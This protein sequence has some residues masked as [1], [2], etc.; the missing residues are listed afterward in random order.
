MGCGASTPKPPSG[1]Q[2]ASA[3]ETRYSPIVK[4]HEASISTL[5]KK[6]DADSDG[7]LVA[8][9]LKD[10]VSKYTGEA[11]DEKQ[12]F[13]WFDVHG[14]GG[15]PDSQLDLKEFGWY[16]ADICESFDEPSKAMSGVIQKF[17]QIVAGPEETRYGHIL[18]GHE[19]A[20]E[21]LFKKIDADNDGHLVASELKGVVEKYTGEAFDEAQFF[22]WF[23]VHGAGGQP[24]SQLDLKEFKSFK[25]ELDARDPVEDGL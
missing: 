21:A 5:F 13:E 24:D 17:E 14:A 2:P 11:F 22:S 18:E 25:R 1:A 3:E 19:A 6:I 16:L 8:G 10:V 20:I 15:Q 23:D 9:E 7:H 4:G 12:F